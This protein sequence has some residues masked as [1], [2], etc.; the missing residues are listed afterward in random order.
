MRIWSTDRDTQKKGR[1]TTRIYTLYGQKTVGGRVQ[2]P[3]D[4]ASRDQM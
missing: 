3:R 4:E 2:Q 1:K